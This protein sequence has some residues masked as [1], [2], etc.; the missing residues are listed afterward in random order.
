MIRLAAPEDLPAVAAIYGEIL[1]QEE[2]R[3]TTYT[4]WQRDAYPTMDHARRAQEAGQLYVDQAEDRAVCGCFILNQEQLPEYAAIP[5]RIPAAPEEVAVIHTLCVSPRWAGRGKAREMVAF[6][7]EAGR[8]MGAKV[9]RLD[10][11]EGNLPA[12]A[13]YPKLGY[14]YAGSTL[15]FFQGFIHEIL[16]CYEKRL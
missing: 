7:E 5:W 8:R 1:D 11:Y 9:I 16:N 4:N 6:C 3:G 2:A 15:F 10:T 12:N 13:M 14:T